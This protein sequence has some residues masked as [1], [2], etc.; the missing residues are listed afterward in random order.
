MIGEM[1]SYNANV[2][3]EGPDPEAVPNFVANVSDLHVTSR[4]TGDWVGGLR[5][6]HGVQIWLDGA[7]YQRKLRRRC[8]P[9]AQPTKEK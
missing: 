7:R 6:G 8:C 2:A 1:A 4:Y 9:T 5:D 3:K